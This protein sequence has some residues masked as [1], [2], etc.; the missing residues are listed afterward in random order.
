MTVTAD[1]ITENLY[2]CKAAKPKI[3]TSYFVTYDSLRLVYSVTAAAALPVETSRTSQTMDASHGSLFIAA[4]AALLVLLALLGGSGRA[5][6]LPYELV[7][8]D[9]LLVMADG[10]F[11]IVA[12]LVVSV[13][14][15]VV[16]GDALGLG[17]AANGAGVLHRTGSDAGA[18]IGDNALIPFVRFD[19]LLIVAECAFLIVVVL[20]VGILVVMLTGDA[21]GL[22]LAANGAGVF[23]RAGSDTGAGIGDDA[24]VPFVGFLSPQTLHS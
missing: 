2:Q 7:R 4:H 11:L 17:L 14:V 1:I 18:G 3:I 19:V 15:V 21:L 22:G 23:H 6:D 24:L 16:A 8:L 13:L 12:V 10:A 20:V 5:V 9:I